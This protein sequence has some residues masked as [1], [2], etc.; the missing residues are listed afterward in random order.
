MLRYQPIILTI[1]INVLWYITNNTLH[2]L[3]ISTIKETIFEFCQKYRDK[4]E[5]HPNNV[6]T[7]LMKT[8]EIV[9]RDIIEDIER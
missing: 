4:L 3:K 2:D 1:I 6:A 7:N 5:E 8:R 9:R